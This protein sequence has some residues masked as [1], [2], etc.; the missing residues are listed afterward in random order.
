MIRRISPPE[1]ASTCDAVCRRSE[2]PVAMAGCGSSSGSSGS[3]GSGGSGDPPGSGQTLTL[4]NAQH[5]ET[6]DAL[7]KA[8]TERTGIRVRVKSD[9]ESVLT[10]QIEQEG[11]RSPAD[12]FFTE[13]SNWLQQL[14]ERGLLA[15]VSRSRRW[16]MCRR[17]TARPTATGSVC[18]GGSA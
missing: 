3:A 14:D 15:K 7:I 4:Y 5:E 8:F 1:A 16:P 12:V 13:N 17:G 2:P 18:P 10:A 9:D 6:T 11:S